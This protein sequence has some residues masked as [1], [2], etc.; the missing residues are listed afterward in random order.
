M[1]TYVKFQ[2]ASPTMLNV[3]KN[4][5]FIDF[6]E[7][8]GH[9]CDVIKRLVNVIDYVTC[10]LG[11]CSHQTTY[12]RSHFQ[13]NARRYCFHRGLSVQGEWVLQSQVLSQVTAPRSFWGVPQS[14]VLSQ[15]TGPRFFPGVAQPGQENGII[16]PSKWTQIAP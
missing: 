14:Q 9:L 3:R 7:S 6:I 2:E 5:F 12:H 4:K 1:K 15:V 16:N 11:D 8:M 13:R 10:I